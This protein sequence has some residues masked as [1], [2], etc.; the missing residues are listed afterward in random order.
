MKETIGGLS[1]ICRALG[2]GSRFHERQG[3]LGGKRLGA[4]DSGKSFA[5]NLAG[6]T[7]GPGP[8]GGFDKGAAA[9]FVFVVGPLAGQPSPA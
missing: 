3:Y 6:R 7:A 8:Q 5:A 2:S 4:L 9:S 1:E